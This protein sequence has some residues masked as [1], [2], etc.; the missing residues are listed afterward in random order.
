MLIVQSILNSKPSYILLQHLETA[1][2]KN[3][4]DF[5]LFEL[6]S[7]SENSIE[8]EQIAEK[9]GSHV[10]IKHWGQDVCSN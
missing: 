10:V 6:V 9:L 1:A 5:G 4:L 7:T 8:A 2:V 3:G